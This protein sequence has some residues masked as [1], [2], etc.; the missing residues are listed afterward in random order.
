VCLGP[1][2][3]VIYQSVVSL[4]LLSETTYPTGHDIPYDGILSILMLINCI[5]Q[6]MLAIPCTIRKE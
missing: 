1:P 4:S 5:A 3:K 6:L 2:C